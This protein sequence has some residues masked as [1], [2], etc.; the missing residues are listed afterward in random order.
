VGLQDAKCRVRV[1]VALFVLF[2]RRFT[3]VEERLD[4]GFEIGQTPELVSRLLERSDLST[5]PR[6]LPAVPN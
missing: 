1:G 2:E 5:L 6:I 3:V 4:G